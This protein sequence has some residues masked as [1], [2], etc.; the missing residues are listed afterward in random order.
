MAN[1]REA[2][3]K[4]LIRRYVETWNKGDIEG[5]PDSGRTT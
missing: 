3:S 4:N 2:E 5:S 1:S